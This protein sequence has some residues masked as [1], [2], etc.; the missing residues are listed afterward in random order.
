[1][2]SNR[3]RKRISK[4][5]STAKS[6]PRPNGRRQTSKNG[7]RDESLRSPRRPLPK[8]NV[9]SGELRAALA[10]IL[11][12]PES[13][14]TKAML[15]KCLKRIRLD[16]ATE[17]SLV[18]E[19]L[20]LR[21]AKLQHLGITERSDVE[22]YEQAEEQVL[23]DLYSELKAIRPSPTKL[24]QRTVQY[25]V[26][27]RKT[28]DATISQIDVRATKS[29]YSV[30][31]YHAGQPR[32][33][34]LPRP[35]EAVQDP[36]AVKLL[37][38]VLQRPVDYAEIAEFIETRSPTVHLKSEAAPPVRQQ[39]IFVEEGVVFLHGRPFTVDDE[40]AR[41]VKHLAAAPDVWFGKRDFADDEILSGTRVDRIYKRLPKPIQKV[42][43]GRGGAGY[44]VV[45]ARLA[46]LR[47]KSSVATPANE[48]H[49]SV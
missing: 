17:A 22:R 45:T 28:V 5:N 38:L 33:R 16:A 41:F 35:G 31:I 37:S 43:E 26:D 24:L 21:F 14:V 20:A 11:E 4:K 15:T 34:S 46:G 47:Q 23:S 10:I 6:L 39:A 19:Y 29:G 44:R 12:I 30:A 40:G 9:V 42:I 2:S 49:N 13:K 18:G 36:F 1:M 7:K 3:F 48:E 32:I 8:S 25:A 27:A